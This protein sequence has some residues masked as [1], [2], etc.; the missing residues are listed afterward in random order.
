MLIAADK[1]N[2]HFL[3]KTVDIRL[4]SSYFFIM[5]VW[6]NLTRGD[7]LVDDRFHT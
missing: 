7:Q 5:E 3:S 6:R 2:Q 4:S 1:A